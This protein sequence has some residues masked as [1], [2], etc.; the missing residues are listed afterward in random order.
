MANVD[1]EQFDYVIIGAGAAGSIIAARLSE[2]ENVTVC[3]LESGPSD[4]RP[5]V[6]VPAGFIKALSQEAVTWQFHTEP[7]EHTGGRAI[8]TTQGRVVGGSGSI[9]GMIYN[10]GLPSDYD[11]W[12][13]MGNRG[14]GYD[15]ILPYFMKT[16]NRIGAGDEDVR[17]RGDG[18]PVTDID[19][20]H[21][22][23]DAFVKAAQDAGLP[24]NADYNDG[25]QEGVGYFQRTI[26]K[27]LRVSSAAAFL[28]P[29]LKR[30]NLK[31]ITSATVT[32]LLFEGTRAVGVAYRR[33][34]S[35]V[36]YEVR[37][38]REVIVCS[39]TVN[40][41]RLLQISGIGPKKVLDDIGVECVQ[42]LAGVGENLRD[43]YAARVVMRAKS[44]IVTLN[45]MVKGP[46]LAL[47][48]AKW[49]LRRPNILSQVPSQV[50]MFCKSQE[51]LDFPDLQCVFTPGSYK[52]GK[53]YILDDYPGVTAGAWQHRPRSKGY[54]RAVSRDVSVAPVIQPNYLD[55]AYDRDVMVAGM[56]FVR[57][58]L[59]MP[60]LSEYLEGETVP[61]PGVVSDDEMLQ[62][63]K[64]NGSTSFHLVGT[65]R[66][67]PASD[68]TAVVD[69]H[70]RVYGI[71]GLRV[72]DASIMP[73]IPSANTYAAS[74]MIGEK[75][76]DLIKETTSA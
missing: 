61:G 24:L 52:E 38:L 26:N 72:A 12:A 2:Q 18:I 29:A 37:A 75:A 31:L 27:G 71:Q 21:P 13:Q 39:G 41:A 44:D 7:T 59:Q 40:T 6:H 47:Q 63:C 11:H 45:E 3:V 48:I 62:F 67:G 30:S 8:H 25:N 10:R 34:K 22:V 54:V 43:H 50:Y 56:K 35:D 17:G 4:L 15:D 42:E 5:Y 70:L 64:E 55:D 1:V 32:R 66:M 49:V 33:P 57:K 74:M 65:A 51:G 19:W 36:V 53:H 76:A 9:N 68:K 58:V 46:R 14:W 20:L 60:R 73:N 16:E 69:D 28:R 23:S